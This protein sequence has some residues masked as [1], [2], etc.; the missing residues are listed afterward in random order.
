MNATM[1]N[2]INGMS[3]KVPQNIFADIQKIHNIAFDTNE[4]FE[5]HP[6]PIPAGAQFASEID[7]KQ[8]WDN[9]FASQLDKAMKR[10]ELDSKVVY[11][12]LKSCYIWTRER[13]G[14]GFYYPNCKKVY[15]KYLCM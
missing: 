6:C 4:W 3:I 7:N 10:G 5:E 1:K 11:A 2:I 15:A 12:Y 8:W 13:Y 14:M 9:K